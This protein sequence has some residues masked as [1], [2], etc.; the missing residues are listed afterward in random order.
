MRSSFDSWTGSDLRTKSELAGKQGR[1]IRIHVPV[2]E[3]E[4]GRTT[5]EARVYFRMV[6]QQDASAF[7]GHVQTLTRNRSEARFEPGVTER[8][9]GGADVPPPGGERLHAAGRSSNGRW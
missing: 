3:S 4:S 2:E 8:K 6:W 7:A 5:H 1:I 9:S